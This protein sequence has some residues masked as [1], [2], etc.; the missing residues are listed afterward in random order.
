MSRALRCSGQ[1]ASKDITRPRP[2]P[3]LHGRV[4]T[5]RAEQVSKGMPCEAM[6]STSVDVVPFHGGR[7]GIHKPVHD[8]IV[9]AACMLVCN[10][11]TH[12]ADK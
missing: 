11:S 7:A 5:H 8:R 6:H 1:A 9:G 3:E 2:C 12:L 4:C 10:I